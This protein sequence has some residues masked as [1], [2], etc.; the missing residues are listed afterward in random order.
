MTFSLSGCEFGGQLGKAPGLPITREL[1]F[2]SH[3]TLGNSRNYLALKHGLSWEKQAVRY[4][5]DFEDHYRVT[6]K[7]GENCQTLEDARGYA[8]ELA[9]QLAKSKPAT[10]MEAEYVVVIDESG[11]EVYRATIPGDD[12]GSAYMQ[13]QQQ[14]Q[15]EHSD[16]DEP[17]EKK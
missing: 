8:H 14:A 5:F 3:P 1:T 7:R 15:P 4:Y 12:E 17:E 10:V 9:K 13:Q 16:E 11:H 6:D 2:R